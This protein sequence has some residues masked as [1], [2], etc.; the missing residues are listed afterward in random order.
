M[1]TV[2]RQSRNDKPKRLRKRKART[3]V[4]DSSDSSDSSSSSESE[5]SDSEPTPQKKSV[6]K[7]KAKP[8][9]KTV[10]RSPSR[11]SSPEEDQTPSGPQVADAEAEDAFTSF[12]L[13]QMTTE[14]AEDLDKIRSAGDFNDKSLGL[15][16]GALKQG[17]ECFDR[18]DRL[19]VGKAI[20]AA[21]Q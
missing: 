11:S 9:T 2:K 13:R 1:P 5:S 4:S 19:A 12:Y 8:K 17:R 6:V 20:V 7:T 10:Q 21:N 18:H 3:D 15:L 16:I 14:F